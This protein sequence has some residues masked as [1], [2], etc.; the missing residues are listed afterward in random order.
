MP[1]TPLKGIARAILKEKEEKTTVTELKKAIM[2]ETAVVRKKTLREYIVI[3]EE[4][5]WIEF[6]GVDA[7]I[8]HPEKIEDRWKE[9]G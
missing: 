2:L 1:W 6:D 4:L 3:A 9:E 5:G 8:M 7:L